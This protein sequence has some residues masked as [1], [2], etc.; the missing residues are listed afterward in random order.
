MFAHRV[1]LNF[2]TANI[3]KAA[4]ELETCEKRGCLLQFSLIKDNAYI[5]LF[6]LPLILP[7]AALQLWSKMWIKSQRLA[8][9]RRQAHSCEKFLKVKFQSAAM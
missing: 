5:L 6:R 8:R 1:Q 3:I 7:P 2:Q 9:R 4:L